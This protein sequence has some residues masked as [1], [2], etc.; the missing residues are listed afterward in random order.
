MSSQQVT[1]LAGRPYAAECGSGGLPMTRRQTSD[2]A[3]QDTVPGVAAFVFAGAV[4]VYQGG[5]SR[6]TQYSYGGYGDLTATRDFLDDGATLLRSTAHGSFVNDGADIYILAPSNDQT[7]DAAGTVKAETQYRY[8]GDLS[9]SVPPGWGDSPGDLTAVRRSLLDGTG[10]CVDTSYTYD[11]YGNRT[12]VTQ[13]TDYGTPSGPFGG[14]PQ[15]T[16]T[17]YDTDTRTYPYTITNALGFTETRTYD[18]HWG[19]PSQIVNSNGGV[20]DYQYDVFGRLT[21]V[22][23]PTA[24]GYRKV[25]TSTYGLPILNPGNRWSTL[26]S[27]VQSTDPPS[28]GSPTAWR[29][30]DGI[31]RL[32]QTQDDH[33]DGLGTVNVV[34]TSYDGRG[35]AVRTS[36]PHTATG[37]GGAFLEDDWANTGLPGTTTAYDELRRVTQTTL[38]DGHTTIRVYDSFNSTTIDQNL[39]ARRFDVDGLGRTTSITEYSGQ[40]STGVTPYA[41][42]SYGY[43]VFD[44]LV[45]VQDAVGH[46]TLITYDALGRKTQMQD[47]NMGLW[48]YAYTPTGALAS[49]TDALGQQT[50]YAY[51]ALNRPIRT[52]YPMV[53]TTPTPASPSVFDLMELRSAIDT[54]RMAC[55]LGA[56][57]WTDP[58]IVARARVTVR[59]V[60]FNELRAAIQDLWTAAGV[61]PIPDFTRGAIVPETRVISIQDLGDV[62]GWL[63]QYEATAFGQIYRARIWQGYDSFDGVTVFGRGRRTIMYDSC[64]N[65]GWTYDIAGRLIQATRSLD[66]FSYSTVT[67]YDGLDRVIQTMLTDAEV[68]TTSYTPRG[69]LGSL[70][71]SLGDVFVS[72]AQY[73]AL[74]LP[75]TYLQGASTLTQSYWGIDAQGGGP[76]GAL[77]S[78]WW[79]QPISG[80]QLSVRTLHYDAAGNVLRLDDDVSGEVLGYAYDELDRVLSSTEGESYAYDQLGR[81]SMR[82]GA[83][84]VYG[85]PAH[86][87]AVTAMNGVSY[88]Y[89]ANGSM[90]AR[91]SLAV[92]Y[93]ARRLPIR[94]DD[95]GAT[96][97]RFAYDG[98]GVRRKRVDASGTVH[99]VGDYE[100]N[101]GDGS[102][103]VDTVTKYYSALGR[104]VAQRTNAV[105]NWIG[106][107]HLGGTIRVTDVNF[108]PLDLMR[109]TPYGIGRDPGTAL[110]TDHLFTSQIQDASTQLYW[111]NS[112][113]YDTW[114]GRFCQPDSSVPSASD[115]QSLNRYAYVRNNPLTRVDPTGHWDLG[116]QSGRA[117]ARTALGPGYVVDDTS[118]YNRSSGTVYSGSGQVIQQTGKTNV[119]PQDMA[120][121]TAVIFGLQPLTFQAMEPA[122]DDSQPGLLPA[123]AQA[124]ADLIAEAIAE[125]LRQPRTASYE[126]DLYHYTSDEG[127]AGILT[128]QAI[129]ASQGGKR[130]AYYG[131]GQYFTDIA[132]EQLALGRKADLSPAQIASGAMTRGMLQRTLFGLPWGFSK[133]TNDYLEV[134]LNNLPVTQ[135]DTHKFLVPNDLPLPVDGRIRSSG[136]TIFHP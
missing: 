11:V 14:T 84:F 77:A 111:F 78:T 51:D 57:P 66:G 34:N 86:P 74:A 89:D 19:R 97:C 6:Q 121:P 100:H 43:D 88:A 9:G 16:T 75:T 1:L 76:Y 79:T 58:T 115:P 5:G 24:N 131:S 104:L 65:S 47:P 93:D 127:L 113:S 116:T 7:L 106:T 68:L 27:A 40:W 128:D 110:G 31:G 41:V 87:H 22:L 61:G 117:D 134:N 38:P 105:L 136:P 48:Q 103:G 39:H 2:W 17:V 8:D 23:G 20:T 92:A 45:N 80:G 81:L 25:T 120:D 55:G 91:N 63:L 94:V 108:N 28:V 56:Y 52:W 90:L 119:K 30:Y 36:V 125:S 32:I 71:S 73:N 60:H 114:I 72:S 42:T 18:W 126:V 101:L 53:W 37:A 70:T 59:A 83:A 29:L 133:Y 49:Q 46:Q 67:S 118:I 54:D 4:H 132:P 50:T 44:R 26:V 129:K 62:R 33:L 112:R 109:Y 85:D 12:T 64:G 102:V 10:R 35:L 21:Q 13:W 15:T 98:D 96:T 135:V 99:Y 107:D 3:L 130:N 69:L 82:N 95:G 123:L 122:A 124:A